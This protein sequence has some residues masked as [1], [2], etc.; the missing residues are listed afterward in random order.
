VKKILLYL[1]PICLVLITLLL[2]YQF[3][4]VPMRIEK[5]RELIKEFRAC[6][7]GGLQDRIKRKVGIIGETEEKDNQITKEVCNSCMDKV[8]IVSSEDAYAIWF[9]VRNEMHNEIK[10]KY[11]Y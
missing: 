5:N 3:A 9:D 7:Q 11:L 1:T 10:R 2:A 4:V 8:G 6:L